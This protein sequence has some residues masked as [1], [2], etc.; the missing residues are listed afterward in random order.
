MRLSWQVLVDIAMS[1]KEDWG[2]P[3]GIQGCAVCRV[4]LECLPVSQC[5]VSFCPQQQL[6]NKQLAFQQQLIQMQQ[7]QQQHL[8]NLQRQGLVSLQ[9]SQGA[10]PMQSL[11][12]GNPRVQ[13]TTMPS[14][15]HRGWEVCLRWKERYII[16]CKQ[17]GAQNENK[18]LTLTKTVEKGFTNWFN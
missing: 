13:A 15:I 5:C 3:E 18:L 17:E 6:G 16:W 11:Q 7:L 8:L 12:Q 1:Q 2:F 4:S 14:F 9:P 10:V